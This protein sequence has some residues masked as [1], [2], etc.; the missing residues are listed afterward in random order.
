MT[1]STASGDDRLPVV[2][3]ALRQDAPGMRIESYY[4]SRSDIPLE[5]AN[6]NVHLA[7]DAPLIDDPQVA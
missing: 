5:L 3:E 6:G 7:I 4:T 1:T 2:G